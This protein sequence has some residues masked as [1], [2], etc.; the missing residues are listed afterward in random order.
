M[1]DFKIIV[2]CPRCGAMVEVV[3]C[4]AKVTVNNT[5]VTPEIWC[6]SGAHECPD[7]LKDRKAR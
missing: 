4:I 1:K 6:A 2:H 3:A 5:Y 7:P